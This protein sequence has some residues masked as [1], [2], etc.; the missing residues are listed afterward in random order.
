MGAGAVGGLIGGALAAAGEH[1]TFIVRPD[2]A[3]RIRTSGIHI[4]GAISTRSVPHP[5][6]ATHLPSTLARSTS[7]LVIIAVKSFHTPAVI[8]ALQSAR[9]KPFDV[10]CLQNGV[11][12]ETLLADA[13][14][15][16][17]VIP[18]T[19]TTAVSSPEPGMV[20]VER[21]RGVGLAAGHPLSLQLLDAFSTAEFRTLLYPNARA[22]KWSKLLT[23]LIANASSA[24]CDISPDAVFAHDRL[25]RLEI[26]AL[27]ETLAVMKGLHLPIVHLPGTPSHWL[28]F[29][30]RNLPAWSYRGFIARKVAA[31]RGGKSP[32]LRMDLANQRGRTEV[33]FLNGAVV[34]HA[35]ALRLSAP[36]NRGFTEILG[37]IVSGETPWEQYRSN[38]DAL[39]DRLLSGDY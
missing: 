12:N 25:Y 30:L 24:I 9:S 21:E 36:V 29:A 18:G 15:Q 37:E 23:N 31:G 33:D 8:K 3:D 14:G 1:V 32:S 2:K 19:L 4:R 38:P 26:T 35:K 27:Q 6:V 16:N 13:L 39:A 34:R 10:L 7:N 20:E 5:D 11:D 22:M 28:A 17:H